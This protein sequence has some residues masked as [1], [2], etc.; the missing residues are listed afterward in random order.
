MAISIAIFYNNLL[1]IRLLKEINQIAI[2]EGHNKLNKTLLHS[3]AGLCQ[4]L[5]PCQIAQ[6]L[7]KTNSDYVRNQL[8]TR[9]YKYIKTLAGKEKEKANWK[10]I[11]KWL[12]EWLEPVQRELNSSRLTLAD[13][14]STPSVKAKEF[15]NPALKAISKPVTAGF[16]PSD[17]AKL[18]KAIDDADK[19]NEEKQFNAALNL[20]QSIIT[21]VFAHYSHEYRFMGILVKAVNCYDKL[22]AYEDVE[23]LSGFALEYIEDEKGRSDVFHYMAGAWHELYLCSK[24]DQHLKNARN[25]YNQARELAKNDCHIL[26]DIF[27]LYVEAQKRGE[28]EIDYITSMKLAWK[29]FLHNKQSQKS[30]FEVYKNKILKDRDRIVQENPDN[31]WLL[32]NL[33]QI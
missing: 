17:L 33:Q 32:D 15:I 1:Y 2:K 3:L 31:Q 21:Q 13:I 9:L 23:E 7:G 4:G 27:D 18:D 19:L 28:G 8:S 30:N 16:L 25:D 20:Y 10:K 5:K 24:N 12:G 11:E 14:S 26:W 6:E 22:K 29:V